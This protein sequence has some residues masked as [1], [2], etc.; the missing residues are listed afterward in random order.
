MEEA[1][2]ISEMY[3]RLERDIGEFASVRRN[4]LGGQ[5]IKCLFREALA[6]IWSLLDPNAKYVIWA[7]DL[8]CAI[9]HASVPMW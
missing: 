3:S 5:I 2:L 8:P 4:F 7:P 6:I 1:T 9:F